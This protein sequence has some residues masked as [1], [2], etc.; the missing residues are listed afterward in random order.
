LKDEAYYAGETAGTGRPIVAKKD[1]EL[2]QTERWGND[3]SY[4]FPVPPGEYRVT[5]RFAETWLKKPGERV[6][7]VLINGEKVLSNLDILHEAK[8]V[9]KGIERIFKSIRP[10]PVGNIRIRFVSSVQNAKVCTLEVERTR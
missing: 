3:F 1:S 9:D 5:L 6:F 10:D 2:F 4:V 7:D 8:A